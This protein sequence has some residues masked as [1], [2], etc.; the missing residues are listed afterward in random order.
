M[1]LLPPDNGRDPHTRH[2][3]P[4]GTLSSP[5]PSLP[6]P[7]MVLAV[8]IPQSSPL[9]TVLFDLFYF[10]WRGH[11]QGK[12]VIRYELTIAPIE[13]NGYRLSLAPLAAG[14]LPSVHYVTDG[15]LFP[16][17]AFEFDR[18]NPF[19]G[20]RTHLY[21]PIDTAFPR[22]TPEALQEAGEPS[23]VRLVYLSMGAPASS[24]AFS[25]RVL[26]HSRI[27]NPTNEPLLCADY[28]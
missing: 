25:G 20:G 12:A 17:L 7:L 24:C 13:L 8:G 4:H 14:R 27:G 9:D 6:G 18:E 16:G 23:P 10:T 19:Q 26:Y 28:L 3:P 15:E 1:D 11:T 21:G 5:L 2:K 22:L